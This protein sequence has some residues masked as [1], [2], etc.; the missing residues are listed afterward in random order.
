MSIINTV[1]V[2]TAKDGG[3]ELLD[4]LADNVGEIPRPLELIGVS[5]ILSKIRTTQIMHYTTSNLSQP[6][7]NLIRFM[8]ADQCGSEGCVKFN[9]NSLK[10]NVG[11]TDEDLAAIKSDPTLAPLDEKEKKLFCFVVA[12][13]RNPE[14]TT[15]EEINE[16]RELGWSDSDIL[17]ATY[18]STDMTVLGSLMKIF[19]VSVPG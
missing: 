16:L 14:G 1:T 4:L 7:M 18:Q 12:A 5:S 2:E 17:E 6:L 9:G 3:K 13:A 8:S 15:Q 10:R 11:I 19:K